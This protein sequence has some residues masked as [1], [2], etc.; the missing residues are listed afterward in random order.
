M[1]SFFTALFGGLY[2]SGKYLKEKSKDN[3]ANK[4]ISDYN[5]LRTDI[6]SKFDT[7]LQEERQA[8]EY[9]LSG[10]NFEEICERF[11]N[12][13][14]FALGSGWK[15]ILDIPPKP[16]YR[17]PI[18]GNYTNHDLSLPCNH[19]YWVYSL[20]LASQGKID[21]WYLTSGF[22]VGGIDDADMN[23]KFA[24]CIEKHLRKYDSS[25]TLMLETRYRILSKKGDREYY[26]T[27]ERPYGGDI[28]LQELC[29]YPSVRL[30]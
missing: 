20:L 19:I 4:R 12:D 9:I 26:I 24:Q 27:R 17:I 15:D 14:E 11:S 18:A 3:D 1:F 23:I 16:T 10:A 29:C 5:I 30:W 2:Y 7:S 25:A 13:F 22:G 28:K 6:K 21:Q 8:K